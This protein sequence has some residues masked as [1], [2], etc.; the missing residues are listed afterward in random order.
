[1]KDN[2]L[3]LSSTE[4]DLANIAP[5]SDGQTTEQRDEYTSKH[6][7]PISRD[8]SHDDNDRERKQFNNGVEPSTTNEGTLSPS[9]TLPDAANHQDSPENKANTSSVPSGETPPDATAITVDE[10]TPDDAG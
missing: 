10:T 2:S 8:N 1:M 7:V 4:I 3:S 6:S 5:Q 9:I